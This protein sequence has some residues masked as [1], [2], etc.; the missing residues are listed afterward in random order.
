MA[1]E[2]T[3]VIDWAYVKGENNQIVTRYM[4][5]VLNLNMTIAVGVYVP[6]E[7]GSYGKSCIYN[8]KLTM[9]L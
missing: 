7:W 6:D 8:T 3:Q 4:M 5:E 1:V 2:D 9:P